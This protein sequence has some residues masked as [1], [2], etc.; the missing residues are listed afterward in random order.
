MENKKQN[1]RKQIIIA[2]HHSVDGGMNKMLALS[3]FE[4]YADL[5]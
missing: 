3:N 1:T 2:P 4:K 5:F